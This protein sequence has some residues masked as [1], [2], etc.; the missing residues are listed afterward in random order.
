MYEPDPSEANLGH[1]KRYWRIT[2][3]FPNGARVSI[4]ES[5][6]KLV[7]PGEYVK[8]Y[9]VSVYEPPILPGLRATFLTPDLAWESFRSCS[10][11]LRE[12]HVSTPNAS[13]R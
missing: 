8:T 10:Q 13:R 5:G 3:F 7:R 12:L 6:R 1:E 9:E 4:R 2:R 11:V